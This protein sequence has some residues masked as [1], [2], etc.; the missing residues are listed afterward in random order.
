MPD[1]RATLK[2]RTLDL[3]KKNASRTY[4]P[5]EISKTLGLTS[6]AD[7][8]LFRDVLDELD[9]DGLVARAKG[10]RYQ[11]KGRADG[12]Q[13]EAIVRV[14]PQ[15]M[16]FAELTSGPDAGSEVF[17]PPNRLGTALDGDHVTLAL[18]A[19]VKGGKPGKL[20]E[21]E[22]TGVVER[23]RSE[24][25]G[26]FEK[27][28]G[29]ALV[30]PDDRRLT[31]DLYVDQPN[32]GG[33]TDGD[34][35]VARIDRYDD[36]RASPEGTVTQVIGSGD[37]P[38]VRVLALALAQGVRAGFPEEVEQQAQ[39][40]ADAGITR[41]EIAR[42]LDLRDKN[43][44]TIDPVDAKDFDDAIHVEKMSDGLYEV[45]VHIADV[46]HYV[47]PGTALDQEAY[48]RGTST[49]LVDR[50]IPMLPEALSNGACSL[51]PHE[52][53]LAYSVIMTLS[54]RGTVKSYDIRE[55]VIHSKQRFAYEEAQQ[56]LD[57][58]GHELADELAM[59]GKL[60]RTLTKKRM[61]AGSV[62]FDTPEVKVILN[63]EGE[64]VDIVK[65]ERQEANR[66]IEEFMLLANQCAAE[67]AGKGKKARPFVYRI[68]AYPDKERVQQLGEYV[69]AFGYKLEHDG[70]TLERS[71]L[72]ELLQHVKGT[73]EQ[74]VIQTAALRAM[75]KAVYSPENIGH[76]GLGFTYYTHFTSPIRRYPDLI[77]HRLLKRY[78]EGGKPAEKEKL[79]AQTRHLSDREK[80]ATEAE[81]ES[82]KLKQTEYV[83]RHIGD[84][85]DGV[86]A[87]VTKFGVFVEMTAL[88]TSGLVHV[89]DM[90]NDY[91]EYD[92]RT[93]Q[94]VG[95]RTRKIIRLGDPVRVRVVAAE[96][97]TRRIDLEFV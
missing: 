47:Q 42:R 19:P 86:V 53:K 26:T 57:E 45:G 6:R 70:G 72:N 2:R 9:A 31:K 80:T 61:R 88:L 50:T 68:H 79:F 77:V 69:R 17:V 1:A 12:P 75:A 67:A 41:K 22:V 97:E 56:V 60:A 36:P 84:E 93:Y 30:K 66:L 52:D 14:A 40:A 54:S 5:N 16:G 48:A 83:A 59:A 21:A 62:D 90:G 82:V 29:F 25:V 20:R 33:A 89:R 87:G 23:S 74:P 55:T 73:R 13:V 8:K 37:D 63:A 39:A 46:S 24:I 95:Q 92:E 28:G 27:M 11:H 81:R 94:M 38:K 7:Y 4:R 49:Y 32:W 15:G 85:F 10:R 64:P 34:K 18:A 43:V 58:G 96:P 78:A 3:L 51:R 44:F 71:D 76:Y 65:K 35:V 91:W